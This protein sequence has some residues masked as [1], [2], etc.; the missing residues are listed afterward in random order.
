MV[1]ALDAKS[2]QNLSF[3][4]DPEVPNWVELYNK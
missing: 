4:E 2:R 3:V 1:V